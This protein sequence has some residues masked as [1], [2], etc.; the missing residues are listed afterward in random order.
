[1]SN[2]YRKL[3]SPLATLKRILEML[4]E[5][6][7][8]RSIYESKNSNLNSS[9]LQFQAKITCRT[10]GRIADA[11]LDYLNEYDGFADADERQ[12]FMALRSSILR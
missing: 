10:Q 2:D 6:D 5:D 12:K 9:K 3:F 4:D 8:E 1:M 7:A 11:F